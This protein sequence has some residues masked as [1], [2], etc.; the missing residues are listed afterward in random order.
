MDEDPDPLK[1]APNAPRASIPSPEISF[2][3]VTSDVGANWRDS[4]PEAPSN[5]ASLEIDADDPAKRRGAV[6]AD[7]TP[8]EPRFQVAIPELPID[9][10]DE[11][12]TVYSQVV[13][14]VNE[15][16][17]SRRQTSYNV[18]FT[19]GRQE[20]VCHPF[21]LALATGRLLPPLQ[22]STAPRTVLLRSA[23]PE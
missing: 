23:R 16:V 5:A 17:G 21:E 6:V 15:A 20:L 4:S 8:P 2:D 22:S 13:E 1:R 18:D 10:R 14:R 7:N 3:F 9:C 19:D 11:Y 12:D